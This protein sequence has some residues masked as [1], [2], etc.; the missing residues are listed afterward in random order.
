MINVDRIEAMA[1]VA[2]FSI[3]YPEQLSLPDQVALFRGAR[4]IVGQYGSALHG[5]MFG[6]PG[7]MVCALQG[8]GPA[9][10][11]YLQSGIAERIGQS[12]GYV[13]GASVD[14]PPPDT[15]FIIEEEAFATC[16]RE[17]FS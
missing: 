12:V 9:C 13:Y 6:T 1:A 17:Q 2:G 7:A 11:G 16:L 3:V 5:T 10:A 15:P 4:Q 8:T 14:W